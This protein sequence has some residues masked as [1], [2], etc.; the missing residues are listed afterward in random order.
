MSVKC[1]LLNADLVLCF[2]VANLLMQAWQRYNSPA[3]DFDLCFQTDNMKQL[4][5]SLTVKQ[6]PLFR[7]SWQNADWQRYLSTYMAGIQHN[8]FKQDVLAAADEHDFVP[9]P[10]TSALSASNTT[11]KAAV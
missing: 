11:N 1:K 10:R 7:L 9:W 5:Q 2:E 4:Q 3:L 6:K 8:V